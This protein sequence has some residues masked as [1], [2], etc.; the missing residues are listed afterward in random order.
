LLAAVLVVALIT[1]EAAV[2]VD[3]EPRMELLAGVAA[4]NHNFLLRI[5]QTTALR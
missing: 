5:Q 1:A 4:Q 2:L 3:I